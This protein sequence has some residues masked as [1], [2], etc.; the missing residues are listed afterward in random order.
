M[1]QSMKEGGYL[2]NLMVKELILLQMEVSMLGN[3]GL[4]LFGT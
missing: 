2:V 3:G 4:G 1:D